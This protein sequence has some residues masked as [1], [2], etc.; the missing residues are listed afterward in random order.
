MIF[1]TGELDQLVKIVEQPRDHRIQI[2]EK[3]FTVILCCHAK[4]TRGHQ[5]TYNWYNKDKPE[6][7]MGCNPILEIP[8]SLS[9]KG[10]RFYCIVSAGAYTVQSRDAKIELETGTVYNVNL[11]AMFH[12]VIV[13]IV[14]IVE[15]P[16][17][18]TKVF[19]GGSLELL[20]EAEAAP[21]VDVNYLWFK[22]YKNGL[23]EQLVDKCTGSK[24]MV[25]RVN[26]FHQGYYKCVIS[27]EI[28]SPEVI[29]P[30]VSSR[31]VYVKV[32][33]PTDIKFTTHPPKKQFIEFGEELTLT[34]EAECENH[35]V[36][37]QWYYNKQRLINAN[38][39]Q[40]V[41]SHIDNEDIGS[42]YCEASSEY[43]GKV[44][45]SNRS[46]VLPIASEFLTNSTEYVYVIL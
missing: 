33:T 14:W 32:M 6:R 9:T 42:Y 4:S 34:C 15:E 44:I 27:P 23:V 31:V 7:S 3:E 45:L 46:Q 16:K 2:K 17:L 28:I 36:T 11:L 21:G 26:H 38:R 19:S 35:P 1:A 12:F 30:E 22:C 43:S 25:S 40:L 13:L 18:V 5:L 10:G 29:S 39:S 20:C 8:M 41:I 37:Y 24:M